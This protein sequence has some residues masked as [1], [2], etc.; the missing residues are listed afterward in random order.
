MA[1]IAPWIEPFLAYLT[2]KE[3]PKDQNEA[4]YIVRRSKAY[5]VHEGELYKKKHYWSPSKVHLR[6]GRAEAFGRNSRRTR[7]APRRNPGP[8]KQGLPYMFLLVDGSGR[9]TTS[10]PRLCWLPA[11]CKPK[12]HATH[13]PPNNPHY[14][15]LHDLGA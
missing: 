10:G 11:F 1:I 14:L 4:R 9:C 3:L 13:R 8:C 7:Q 15:A 5:R 2:R 12:P 6:R